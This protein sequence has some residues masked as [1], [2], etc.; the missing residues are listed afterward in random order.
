[1]KT[2]DELKAIV[3]DL[4]ERMKPLSH[5]LE[6]SRLSLASRFSV[7]SSLRELK[8][9]WFEAM[10]E[11]HAHPEYTGSLCYQKENNPYR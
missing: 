7:E 10:C 4:Q 3:E 11:Y 9:M 2:I 8:T 6:N 1:M 5:K